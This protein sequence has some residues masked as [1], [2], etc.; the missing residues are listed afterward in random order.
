VAAHRVPAQLIEAERAQALE[1][2][3]AATAN[4]T[5]VG[6]MNEF[7]YLADLNRAEKRD[8]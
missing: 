2:R 3:L 1:P 4:R 7:A 6:V 8:C 5:L